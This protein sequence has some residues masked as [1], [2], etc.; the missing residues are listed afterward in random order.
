MRPGFHGLAL[1]EAQQELAGQ[2]P[3]GLE[4]L[5][6]ARKAGGEKVDAHHVVE[7]DDSQVVR[8]PAAGL[9]QHGHDAHGVEVVAGDHSGT[10]RP[11][12][13]NALGCLAAPRLEVV[14]GSEEQA[15]VGLDA[16]RGE[17]VAVGRVALLD[18]EL[19]QAA[20]EGYALMAVLQEV[21]DGFGHAAAVV[22]EH[23]RAG[24]ARL[25]VA[26][27]NHRLAGPAEVFEVIEWRSF[28]DRHETGHTAPCDPG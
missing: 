9:F 8:Y 21:L 27:G 7:A 6:D 25:L 22:G 20:G 5:G 26:D 4:A 15:R 17:R 14:G 2:R 13:Q 3:H 1:N 24:E 28:G 23:C 10:G 11:G 12:G 18:I 19:V 16:V